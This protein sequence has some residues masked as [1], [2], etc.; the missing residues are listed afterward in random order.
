MIDKSSYSELIS[1]F[2]K[3][4][5]NSLIW[6]Y[7]SRV[8]GTAHSG[9]DLDLAIV[10]YGDQD[11]DYLDIKEAIIDSNIP[12]LIDIFELNRLPESFRDEIKRNYIVLYSGKTNQSLTNL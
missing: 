7:G 6:A 5:P 10:D 3:L 1:I 2:K 4:C 11:C 8:N 12:F 9:S